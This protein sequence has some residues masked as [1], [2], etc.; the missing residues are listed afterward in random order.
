MNNLTITSKCAKLPQ[1]DRRKLMP[2][3]RPVV[4]LVLSEETRNE[5]ETLSRSRSLPH[6]L[7]RRAH[8]IL[9]ASEEISHEDIGRKVGL[10]R[11]MVGM[12]RKRFLQQGLMGLYDEQ[13]PGG[14]RSISDEQ[15]SLLIRKTL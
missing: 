6:A 4:P 5:L 8:I 3:G 14:P 9:L 13:R 15:V 7:V 11:A 10:S 2:R 1:N 12:W